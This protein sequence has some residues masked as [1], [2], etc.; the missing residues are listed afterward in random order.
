MVMAAWGDLFNEAIEA[1]PCLVPIHCFGVDLP[2]VCSSNL[3]PSMDF[4]PFP[5]RAISW[6]LSS[7][8]ARCAQNWVLLKS[9]LSIILIWQKSP[10]LFWQQKDVIFAPNGSQGFREIIDFTLPTVLLTSRIISRTRFFPVGLPHFIN[11][12]IFHV[13]MKVVFPE[14]LLTWY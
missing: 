11:R 4:H 13:V 12:L 3:F 8:C 1:S 10:Q 14:G 6:R 9:N 7:G 5:S 2:F